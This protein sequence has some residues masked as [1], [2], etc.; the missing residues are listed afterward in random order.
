MSQELDRLGADLVFGVVE[1]VSAPDAQ[2]DV[3]DGQRQRRQ[4]AQADQAQRF[5]ID[6]GD[7]A[8]A[9]V[10]GYLEKADCRLRADLEADLTLTLAQQ[11][12][13]RSGTL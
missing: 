1:E 3:L 10:F 7:A 11:L 5:S 9:P 13:G 2:D 4:R 6:E 8:C 12:F